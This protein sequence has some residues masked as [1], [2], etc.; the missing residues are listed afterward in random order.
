MIWVNSSRAPRW[1]SRKRG[2]IP[3]PSGRMRHNSS[4]EPGRMVGL[5]LPTTP[6]QD[7]NAKF[8]PYH[9]EKRPK[10][11]VLPRH[12]QAL[13]FI[14]AAGGEQSRR[15]KRDAWPARL[16]LRAQIL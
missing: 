8:V 5:M 6:R 10:L 9:A 3:T 16:T 1:I 13:G 7:V 2:M 12:F 11:S 14:S 4:M 15:A